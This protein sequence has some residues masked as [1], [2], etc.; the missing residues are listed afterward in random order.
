MRKGL[1]DRLAEAIGTGLYSG[2]FPLFP[3]TVGSVTGIVVYLILVRLG[4]IGPQFS[5]GWPIVLAVMFAVGTFAAHRCEQSF[6]HDSKRIVIDEVWG[7]LISL[8][9]LPV[10]WRWILAAFVLF[11]IFDI[12][13]PF[14]GRRAERVGG[15]IAVM[16]DDGVAGAYTVIILHGLRA[17]MG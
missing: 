17:L 1:A 10:T 14:P 9:L 15:G 2:Y 12:I 7:Q 13:K 8:F 4:V 16:L 3:G 6:G 5:I 11:R